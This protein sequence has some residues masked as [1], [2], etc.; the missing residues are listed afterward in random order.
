MSKHPESFRLSR[1]FDAPQDIL[2]QAW[3]E[4]EHLGQWF[5]PKGFS[6]EVKKLEL[7]AGGLYHYHLATPEGYNLWGRWVFREIKAPGKLVFVVSLSDEAGGITRHPF[8]PDWPLE[9]L[10]TVTLEP[11]GRKTHVHLEWSPLNPTDAERHAFDTGHDGMRQGW[12]G[13]FEQLDTYLR[14]LA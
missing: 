13:T 14:T 3:T 8:S 10:S 7:K 2:W 11:E 5:S 4:R 6:I 9:T 12:G 1:R